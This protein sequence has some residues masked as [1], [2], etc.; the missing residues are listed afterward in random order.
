MILDYDFNMIYLM[1]MITTSKNHGHQ[2]NH[3]KIIV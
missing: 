1:A 3:I 2:I